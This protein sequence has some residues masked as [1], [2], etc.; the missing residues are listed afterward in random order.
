MENISFG[1]NPL[2]GALTIEGFPDAVK[3]ICIETPEA[4]KLADLALHKADLEFSLSCL[5]LLKTLPTDAVVVKDALWISS[6]ASYIKCFGFSEARIHLSFKK[7]YKGESPIAKEVFG[8]FKDLRNK[9]MLHDENS[10]SQCFSGAILNNEKK[11]KKIEK[12]ICLGVRVNTFS[13]ENLAQMNHLVDNALNWVTREFDK[14][15]ER[16]SH[17]LEQEPYKELLAKKS[18]EYKL[19]KVEEVSVSRKKIGV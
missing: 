8:Y 9:H 1:L 16:I 4:R 10:Y 14:L 2:K 5:N 19:P 11:E 17:Q 18:I 7:I 15:C 13:E 6:I 12:V 3:V